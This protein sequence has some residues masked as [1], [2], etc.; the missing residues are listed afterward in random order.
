MSG[1]AFFSIAKFSYHI[2]NNSDFSVAELSELSNAA[3][4]PRFFCPFLAPVYS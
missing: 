3:E 2:Q 1:G 4:I